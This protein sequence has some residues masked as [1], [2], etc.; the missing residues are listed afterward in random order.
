[1]SIRLKRYL[2]DYRVLIPGLT[3]L[4]FLVASFI[5]IVLTNHPASEV[6]FL[7]Y[8]VVAGVNVTGV[9]SQL[10]LIPGVGLVLWF[11]DMVWALRLYVEERELACILC[12]VGCV[13]GIGV[14]WGVHLLLVFNG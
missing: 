2:H 3:G 11:I 4:A 13:M 7:H 5:E 9:W 8:S 1:M 12:S 14:W 6:V 10:Y